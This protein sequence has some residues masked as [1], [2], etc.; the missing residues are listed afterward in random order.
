[1]T[2][3]EELYESEVREAYKQHPQLESLAQGIH[4]AETGRISWAQLHRVLL[5]AVAAAVKQAKEDKEARV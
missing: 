3:F 5:V 2:N 1:M 4:L